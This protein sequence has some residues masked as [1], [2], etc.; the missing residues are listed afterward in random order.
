[1]NA[2]PQHVACVLHMLASNIPSCKLG[3]N[4]HGYFYKHKTDLHNI[5]AFR[6]IINAV[7]RL[8]FGL[9]V[10]SETVVKVKTAQN[11]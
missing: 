6:A 4:N 10:S 7:L 2:C 9:Y 11:T 1:M 8:C 3:Q 5:M